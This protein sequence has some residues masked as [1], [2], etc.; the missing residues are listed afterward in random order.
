MRSKMLLI[1]P[2]IKQGGA[3]RVMSELANEWAGQNHEV[4]LVLLAKAEKFYPIKKEIIVHDLGFENNGG[5]RRFIAEFRIFLDLR[6]LLKG[7]H[8]DFVLSFMTKYNIL[9]LLAS[10]FLDLRIFVSDRS[11]PFKNLPSHLVFFRKH[12]YKFATGIIAQ[13]NTAKKLLELDTGNN[14]IETIPNP[15]KEIQVFPLLNREKIILNI[16]RLVPEKGQKY[17]LEAFSK[18]EDTSWKLVILGDGPLKTELSNLAKS[19][20]ITDRFLMPG[21]VNNIDEWL[22]KSSIFVF[23]SIS[24]GFPNALVEAMAAGLPVIS[25]DCDAG[26]RDIIHQNENGVL[27]EEKD[28]AG[29]TEAIN[30]LIKNKD[31]RE[32]LGRNSLQI[33]EQFSLPKIAGRY[34]DFMKSEAKTKKK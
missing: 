4:H 19:Y 7:E 21:S 26:P 31:L 5:F 22:A 13:T 3:E 24:E 28:V 10:L 12:T 2:T 25:F 15:V 29:L 34:F 27:I 32:S 1:I 14:N 16:G 8:P 9:T 30:N 17:L 33:R 11:N 23:S 18:I 20:K 6:N